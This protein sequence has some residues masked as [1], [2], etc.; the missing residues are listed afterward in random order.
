MIEPRIIKKYPNRRL[1]DTTTSTYITLEDVKQRVISHVPIKVIDAK[2]EEDI[3]NSAL[4]QIIMELE[5]KGVPFLTTEILQNIIRFTPMSYMNE[6]TN[7]N[8]SLWKNFE[9]EWSQFFKK[10]KKN[11]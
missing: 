6:M 5:V 4:L 2:T 8:M 1:Y 10:S 9:E 3:T 7:K 11:G